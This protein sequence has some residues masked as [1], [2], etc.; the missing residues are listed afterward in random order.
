MKDPTSENAPPTARPRPAAFARG[1]NHP[2]APG[3]R[4]SLASSCIQHGDRPR[5]VDGIDGITT[6]PDIVNQLD[7]CIVG[8]QAW[9][10]ASGL[11]R[12]HQS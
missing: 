8:A 1:T 7:D 6:V 4:S 2:A 12:R 11:I 5:G 3:V 10:I 9:F